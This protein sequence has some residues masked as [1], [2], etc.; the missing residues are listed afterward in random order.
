MKHK[1]RRFASLCFFTLF[2]GASKLNAQSLIS[3]GPQPPALAL[4]S[5]WKKLVDS[6]K[7]STV[8]DI[9]IILKGAN[10]VANFDA[11]QKD[12]IIYDKIKYLM[13]LTEAL[14]ELPLKGKVKTKTPCLNPAFP[15]HPF[16]INSYDIQPIK[17]P[18]RYNT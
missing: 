15:S 6:T 7:N 16:Y 2:L 18:W 5:G 4:S 17:I 14:K 11:A 1:A 13:P 8:R 12:I 10:A 9:A 3:E